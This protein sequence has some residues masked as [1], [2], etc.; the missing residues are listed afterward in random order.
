M[1]SAEAQEANMEAYSLAEVQAHLT[2]LVDRVA[3]G[4]S[5]EIV[6][7]GKAV[8][9][10]NPVVQPEEPEPKKAFDIEFLRSLT[11][12]MP[13]TSETVV[14]MRD[15]ARYWR[16]SDIR[17][18]RRPGWPRKPEARSRSVRGSGRKRP[19]LCPARCAYARSTRFID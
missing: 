1:F 9:Q 13:M 12:G 3:A 16:R 10:I 4:E 14:Q 8:A 6:R 7:D 11:A 15:E 5:V 19:A 17:S 18:R 2:E